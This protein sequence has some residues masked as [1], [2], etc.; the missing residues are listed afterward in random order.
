MAKYDSVDRLM[1]LATEQPTPSPS[2]KEAPEGARRAAG[3]ADERPGAD[4]EA[5]LETEVSRTERMPSS[6][7]VPPGA[8]T[9]SPQLPL[10][11]PEVSA[12]ERGRQLLG[13]LRPFLPAVGSA[14]RL[15]DHGAVQA[16]ARMLPMLGTLGTTPAAK[17]PKADQQKWTESLQAGEQ[18]HN[19]L[20]AE[21]KAQKQRT[22]L[23][24][25]QLRRQ[26]ENLERT[27]AEQGSLSRQL[28]Q[29]ADRSRLL[30]ATTI[31]LVMVVAAELVL[32][33]IFL[34]R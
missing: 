17:D 14:L 31:I 18:R 19:E 27:V 32:L 29:L 4:A 16:V 22:E 11:Q 33:V 15:V 28:H 30:T 23:L 12:A 5:V 8:A 13:A 24:E 20:A 7:P 34:H 26:R 25:E 3:R 21:L 2:L 10:A 6:G 1:K 9:T